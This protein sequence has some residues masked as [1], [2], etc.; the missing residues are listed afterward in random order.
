MEENDK[1]EY[2]NWYKTLKRIQKKELIL[3]GVLILLAF[4]FVGISSDICKWLKTEVIYDIVNNKWLKTEVIHDIVNNKLLINIPICIIIS[5]FAIWWWTKIWED[6]DIRPYRLGL[7]ISLFIIT[8]Y[9]KVKYADITENFSYKCFF[10]NLL[11]ISA[12]IIL[13]RFYLST[14]FNRKSLSEWYLSENRFKRLKQIINPLIYKQDKEP[15]LKGFSV[16]NT[17]IELE[18]NQIKYAETL[19]KKLKNTDLSKESFAVGITGEWGS[20]KSTFLNTMKKEIKEAKFAEIVEFNPWLCNSPEQVTQDFF[21]TL[22][23]EL[24]PKHS[25]LSRDINKY[26]KLLNKIAKASLSIFGIDLDLT[27]S[28]D[29]LNKLKDKISNKLANL[30][31]KVVI[32]IDDT[33]RLEG[34]EVFEILRLIRN[35]ADFK[36]VIYIATYDKEYVTDVLKGNKIKG[37]DNYLEKIFQVEV[38]LPKVEDYELWDTLMKEIEISEDDDFT[39]HLNDNK[40]L[41]L[42]IL[43]N[44]RKIKRFAR[45]YLLFK[46]YLYSYIINLIDLFWL[47]LLHTYDKKTYN[48]LANKPLELLEEDNNL[49]TFKLKDNFSENIQDEQTEKILHNMFRGDYT[50]MGDIQLIEFYDRYFSMNI[51][52]YKLTTK[53]YFDFIGYKTKTTDEPISDKERII[54]IETK[55]RDWLKEGKNIDS[56]LYYFNNNSF[57]DEFSMDFLKNKIYSLLSLI[58]IDPSISINKIHF[59]NRVNWSNDIDNIPQSYFEE[60]I[61]NCVSDEDYIKLSKSLNKLYT[62]EIYNINQIKDLLIIGSDDIINYLNTIIKNYLNNNKDSL[63]IYDLISEDK[64]LSQIFKNCCVTNKVITKILFKKSKKHELE[65]SPSEQIALATIIQFFNGKLSKDT[66]DNF[67]L[68]CSNLEKKEHFFGTDS[69]LNINKLRTIQ[70]NG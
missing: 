58:Y 47:Q 53:E 69:R 1:T 2:R 70:T 9:S 19:V 22:I 7:I 30:P 68:K 33:D 63:K 42:K 36:N 54:H 32:L 66:L 15:Q 31:K 17:E 8:H 48:I 13:I 26:A 57:R 50:T 28:D 3:F 51:S 6:K 62:K 43:T 20:G 59:L 4:I 21:A 29:S 23:N 25:T 38:H 5:G 44:Y 39:Q 11:V 37:P 14:Y 56:I 45:K 35:T 49:T 67:I 18:D 60:K 40:K 41:I 34:N 24:S 61:K 55:I 46:E 64:P 12:I 27:P 10:I 16:D 65:S 52:K